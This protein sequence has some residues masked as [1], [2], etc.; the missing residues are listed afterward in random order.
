MIRLVCTTSRFACYSHFAFLYGPSQPQAVPLLHVKHVSHDLQL[1]GHMI[2]TL[3][4]AAYTNSTV[5]D[6][7]LRS[8]M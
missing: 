5:S 2:S 4:G 3:P 1:I 8:L 7:R 6:H